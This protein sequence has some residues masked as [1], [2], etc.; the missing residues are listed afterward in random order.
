[1]ATNSSGT[2]VDLHSDWLLEFVAVE[3]VPI[4]WSGGGATTGSGTED[5]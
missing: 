5:S 1:M 4:M 3:C 2:N